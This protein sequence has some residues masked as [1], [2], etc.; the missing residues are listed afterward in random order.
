[1][2]DLRALGG[3]NMTRA[4]L[5]FWRDEHL[6]ACGMLVRRGHWRKAQRRWRTAVELNRKLRRRRSGAYV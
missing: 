3:S 2:R 4:S 1:M 5:R 6:W